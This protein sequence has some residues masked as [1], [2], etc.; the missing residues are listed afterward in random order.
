MNS[1]EVLNKLI[2]ET[3]D[4]T[5]KWTVAIEKL[6]VRATF[7]KELTPKKK[8]N[9]K[10]LYYK[11]HPK[12][13]SFHIYFCKKDNWGSI[14][15]TVMDIGGSK[16]RNE[17]REVLKFL[18]IILLKEELKDKVE[19]EL[20]D[21]F[22]I[23]D[24]VVVVKEQDFRKD[25]IIGQKGTIVNQFYKDGLKFLVEFD[26]NFSYLLIN[27]DFDYS[28]HK[29]G[30]GRCWIMDPNNIRKINNKKKSINEKKIVTD[31]SMF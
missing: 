20:D 28:N 31:F 2:K 8:L 6:I 22:S 11:E 30:N 17:S 18:N 26:N 5:I 15:V 21:E 1:T 29:L 14:S 9:F 25:D 24:R 27:S 3:E 16:K 13:T 12:N 19:I 23:G 10:I 7:E 4:N